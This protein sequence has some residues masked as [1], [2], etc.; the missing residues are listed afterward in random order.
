MQR[1]LYGPALHTDKD[2]LCFVPHSLEALL[3]SGSSNS[4]NKQAWVLQVKLK[5]ENENVLIKTKRKTG[6]KQK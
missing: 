1:F 4:V 2:S 5:H 3:I 6:G